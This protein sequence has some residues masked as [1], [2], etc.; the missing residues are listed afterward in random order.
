[1]G[2]P[3]SL[4]VTEEQVL[5]FRARRGHLAGPGADDAA[6][7]ARAI[8]G[9]QS[10]QLGPSL[11]ALSQRLRGGPTAARLQNELLEPPRKLV[12][13]WG[14]RDTIHVYDAAS[15]WAH[16]VAAR[17]LWSPPGRRG[18]DPSKALLE[19]AGEL[20]REKGVVTRSDLM[21]LLPRAF[22]RQA[23][24]RT[25]W[26]GDAAARFA[27]GR[28]LWKLT[29]TGDAC[30]AGKFGA[31]QGYACRRAWFPD[32]AWPD[33]LPSPE[34]ACEALARRYLEVNGP[35]SA[36]DLAHF[37]GARI[38]AARSW[39]KRLERKSELVR[40]SCEGRRDLAL[41]IEDVE[42][43]TVTPPRGKSAWPVRM[44]PQWDTK[45][46][47]HADKSWTVPDESE[48]KLVW[49]ASAVVAAAVLARGRVVATWTQAR[50]ARRLEITVQPLRL[51][52][53]GYAK[54]VA[55]EA[56]GIAAH[57][58]LGDVSVDILD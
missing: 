12:R 39:I 19:K 55:R 23:E 22:V 21:P 58:E 14:Q 52:R 38:S 54:E 11:V 48:R 3:A 25:G 45:L 7:A 2:K 31:E 37:F 6:A 33:P 29:H 8:L 50:K 28:V 36:S 53:S 13:T 26:T 42:D 4:T 24:V 46:M 47:G 51:W 15:D 35:A 30:L 56:E 49:R 17:R 34:Q 9:A 44:L 57:L 1:M 16:V 5:Y 10:Q 27:A 18:V 40:V 43:L 41:L 32:L 20:L